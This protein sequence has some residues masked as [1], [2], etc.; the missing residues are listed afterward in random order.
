MGTRST[1]T[2]GAATATYALKAALDS[3]KLSLGALADLLE[4]MDDD[5]NHPRA[6]NFTVVSGPGKHDAEWTAWRVGLSTASEA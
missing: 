3:G 5:L 6:R 4:I 1:Q 2:V